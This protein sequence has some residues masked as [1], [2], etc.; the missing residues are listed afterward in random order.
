MLFLIFL[1][2]L[3]L[4]PY[5]PTSSQGEWREAFD[6]IRDNLVGAESMTE[7]M[8]DNR[9]VRF[10]IQC[11]YIYTVLI[12]FLLRHHYISFVFYFYYYIFL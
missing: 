2:F 4:S 7:V 9:F 12:L 1:T 3:R 10:S 11:M 6:K 8:N 5:F